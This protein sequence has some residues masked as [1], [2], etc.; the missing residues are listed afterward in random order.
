[1][2]IGPKYISTKSGCIFFPGPDTRLPGEIFQDNGRRRHRQTP[3][4]LTND[5][6]DCFMQFRGRIFQI[7]GMRLE[8]K[9]ENDVKNAGIILCGHYHKEGGHS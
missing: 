2:E 6:V 9:Q 1:M 4:R 7:G 8:K 3:E 5:W